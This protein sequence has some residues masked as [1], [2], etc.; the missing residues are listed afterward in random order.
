M[1]M[2]TYVRQIATCSSI[3][4]STT[5]WRTHIGRTHFLRQ[6]LLLPTAG[7]QTVLEHISEK[8]NFL[9]EGDIRAGRQQYDTYA[10]RPPHTFRGQQ[11]L[12]L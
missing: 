10:R 8:E 12:R 3:R 6:Q 11:V 4:V 9:D 2:Y 7:G 5:I 1:Y